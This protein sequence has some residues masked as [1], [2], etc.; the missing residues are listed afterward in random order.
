MAGL[1]ISDDGHEPLTAREPPA[2]GVS[3]FRVLARNA[4]ERP[5]HA[6]SRAVEELDWGRAAAA[7]PDLRRSR[8]CGSVNDTAGPAEQTRPR[9]LR[10]L[11][12]V[13]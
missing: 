12:S 1:V 13:T 10:M 11:F 2:A 5:S 7:R 4:R 8:L 3:T 6:A 9:K